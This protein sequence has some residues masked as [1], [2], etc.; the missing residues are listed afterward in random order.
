MTTRRTDTIPDKDELLR[1]CRGGP[2]G[3]NPIL[4]AATELALLHEMWLERATHAGGHLDDAR[5]RWIGAID[6]LVAAMTPTPRPSALLH[7]ETVG[8]VVD[9]MAYLTALAFTTLA[10]EPDSVFHHINVQLNDLAV[11]YQHLVLEL[12]AGAKHLPASIG[13]LEYRYLR[14]QQSRCTCGF[15]NEDM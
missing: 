9:R 4:A 3:D 6:Y 12:R 11:G 13:G 7:T 2:T 1:V 8:C 10:S 5:L 15:T 14:R